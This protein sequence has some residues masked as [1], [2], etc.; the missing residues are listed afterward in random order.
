MDVLTVVVGG[1]ASLY[2]LYT[3]YLRS[4]RP[5]KLGKLKAMK[6]RWGERT[7]W[8]VHCVAYSAIP[9]A[10]GVVALVLGLQGQSIL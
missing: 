5:D 3:I 7:G 10:F 9:L 2:G 1:A 6:E 8:L 4:Q